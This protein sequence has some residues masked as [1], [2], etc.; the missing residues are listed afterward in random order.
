MLDEREVV[1]ER[2]SKIDDSYLL[3][4]K[5][6]LAQLLILLVRRELVK[7][8][9]PDGMA[10]LLSNR[11]ADTGDTASGLVQPIVPWKG[12]EL[13]RFLLR[14]VFDTANLTH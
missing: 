13:R 8:G 4:L 12:K 7:L 1:E 3:L 2:S 6:Q 11:G 5:L 10:A 14:A 9:V